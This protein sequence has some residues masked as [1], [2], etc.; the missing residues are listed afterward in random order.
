MT[1]TSE[2]IGQRLR[3]A[4][5]GRRLTQDAIAAALGLPRSA[6]SLMESGQRQL[7][8][9]ELTRL[10]ALYGQPMDWFVRPNAPLEP[11]DPV[12]T[13]FRAEP[14]LQS[15]D[16]QAQAA[17]CLGLIRDGAALSRLLGR[18]RAATL[19]RYDLPEARSVGQAI[20]QGHRVADQ[21]R[22][23]LDLGIAPVRD[24]PTVIGA[25]GL[26]V[27]GLGLP[28]EISGLF[29]KSPDFG[30]A[31]LINT[32]HAPVR[33]RF[34]YAHEYGHALM[35]RDAPA[36]I[37]TSTHNAKTRPEQRANAFAA[38]F[39]MPADG[40]RDFMAMLGK[41]RGTRREEAAIDPATGDGIF[42]EL[43]SPPRS[44]TI[45]FADVA[46]LSRHF[47]AS[48]PAAVW[49]LRGLAMINAQETDAL[50]TQNEDANRYLRAV[51]DF[52]DVDD[53]GD[54]GG[55]GP[56]EE[57]RD[58]ALDRQVLPLALEAWRREEISESRLVE[59]GQALGI[60]EDM[61]RDLA[62]GVSRR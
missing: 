54:G 53:S 60:D 2:Q 33:R 7:S 39:L 41:G 4:R 21:E 49:R 5:E 57:H 35:D 46:L 20:A 3:I 52:A 38:A 55:A 24:L 23:R 19:P 14:G 56:A 45:T 11:G 50:I 15:A 17:R 47:G 58:H 42:G 10:A 6:I 61:M 8:T 9:L 13:L 37:T 59:I 28:Q 34:S 32:A 1:T 22:R 62:D 29:L 16:V 12:V 51:R 43:R 31:I 40:V 25:Q 48:Y 27:A 18:D 26:W 36:M 30:L 44:Q